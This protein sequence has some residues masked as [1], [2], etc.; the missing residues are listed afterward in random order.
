MLKNLLIKNYALIKNLEIDISPH[1]NVI[2]GETGAGKSIML[3]AVGLL[4]G[5]RSDS[6][7]LHSEQEKCLIEGVFDISE[8]EI[9][10][11]FHQNDIDFQKQTVVRREVTASG[12]TRAFINDTP[13]TVELLKELGKF[14]IDVHSQHDNLLLS[15]NSFQLEVVDMYAEN[16]TILKQYQLIFT[17]YKQIQKKYDSLLLQSESLKKEFD[18]NT[19]L[20]EELEKLDIKEGEQE[21]LEQEL[22]SLEN[23]EEIKQKINEVLLILTQ[24][25]FSIQAQFSTVKQ[26]LGQVSSFSKSI[27]KIQERFVSLLIELQDIEKDL[28]RENDHIEYDENRIK[29]LK[30]KLD[31]LYLLQKKHKAK[32]IQELIE[33]KES[34]KEKLLMVTNFETDIQELHTAKAKKQA[35]LTLLSQTLTERR[36]KSLS[37]LT[38]EILALIQ[39]LGMPNANFLIKNTP[40]PHTP[41]G[42]DEIEFLFSANKGI[43]VKELKNLASGGELSR[44]MFAIKYILA[45]KTSMPTII[46]DE[47]ETGISG[48]VANKMVKMMKQ[49]SKKHQIIS[50][51]H[52]PQFAAK[53]DL[54]F[55]VYKDNSHEKTTSNIKKLSYEERVIE[56]AKM[57]AGANP[58]F[59][60]TENARELLENKSE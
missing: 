22:L 5:N 2:T 54:H 16:K 12:K 30:N 6:K 36:N 59:V 27:K 31:T 55:F 35:E 37:P 3:G 19:Y 56:I 23:S 50:I 9:E 48:E 29:T 53:G 46:F 52:L 24:D 13:T 39:D 58:S 11:F 45:Q 49:M 33:I 28:I 40:V 42:T 32:T 38:A 34:L 26:A 17:E 44:L 25:N 14:L 15:S 18:Y 7:T 57:I 21:L 4:M 60:A 1:M 51:T 20:W 41:Q 10:S 43:L 47:I 8:Y